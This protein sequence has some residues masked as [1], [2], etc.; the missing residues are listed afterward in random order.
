MLSVT[1]ISAYLIII[2]NNNNNP[3]N[4]NCIMYRRRTEPQL[5]PTSCTE[6]VV[7]IG[8]VESEVCMRTDMK[9][10]RHTERLIAILSTPTGGDVISGRS[11]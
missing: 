9:A 7:K 11:W 4:R 1:E 8:H 3:Q 10:Y 5:Q 2:I 6:T